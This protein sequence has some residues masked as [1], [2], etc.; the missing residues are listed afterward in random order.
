MKQKFYF[1]PLLIFVV[2]AIVSSAWNAIA[3][4]IEG[5]VLYL[6]FE[7]AGSLVDHSPNPTEVSIKG[8]LK[9]VD[10]KFGK[11]LEF[12]G[13]SANIIEVQHSGK[14][15]GMTALT[16][17][18]WVLPRDP[19]GQEGMSIASKREAWQDGD[20]YNL[21]LWTGQT[22]RARVNTEGE[23]A[24]KTVFEDGQ[25][26]HVACVFDGDASGNDRTK[27]YINGE[28]EASGAHPD[29][30]VDEGGAPLWIGELDASR[31]FA[32]NGII[33]EVG[34][35]SRSLSQDEIRLAMEGKGKMVSV[36]LQGKL[37]TTWGETKKH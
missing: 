6:S 33:D 12:D 19:A 22:M 15:E 4:D 24:S 26:Y 37:T 28:L 14:L 20:V 36:K 8:N 27:L 3:E 34:I 29:Q 21:F 2:M 10:G 16:I 7:E 9:H 23:I 5:L 1:V 11:A 13:N 17:E 32:W 35:W 25:W 31:G 30:S 18:A